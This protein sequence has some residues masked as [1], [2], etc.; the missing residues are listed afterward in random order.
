MTLTSVVEN[1]SA[2]IKAATDLPVKVGWIGP[3][4]SIPL[5]TIMHQGGG[6]EVMAKTERTLRVYEFQ[7]DIWHRSAKARDEAYEKIVESLLGNW[8]AHY[9]NY[10]WW[11]ATIYRTLDIEEEGVYRKTML[12]V[13]KEVV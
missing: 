2:V 5:I 7:I 4:D 6:A 11:A 10:G 8:Q 13:L 9:R 1:L 3:N 12:L